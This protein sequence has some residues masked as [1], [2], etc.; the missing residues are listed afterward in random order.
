MRVC[1]EGN[2]GAGKSELLKELLNTHKQNIRVEPVEAWSLLPRYYEDPS[3]YAF[4]L[5]AQVLSSYAETLP[6][7]DI[8]TA[9]LF[10]ERNER[11]SMEVFSKLLLDKGTMTEHQF[12]ILCALY[13]EMPKVVPNVIIYLDLQ[14]S[15]CLERIQ[16][17]GREFESG[18]DLQYLEEL[19]RHYNTYL[20]SC[21]DDGIQ[22]YRLSSD[23][24]SVSD[25]GKKVL[26]MLIK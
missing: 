14:P 20:N 23:N 7:Q 2:I 11:S 3:T 8:S 24:T 13:L 4:A 17:R 6:K 18:I 12:S 9:P 10:I 5:Q 22:V 16:R 19:D 25:L 1:I 15:K 21:K 26:N